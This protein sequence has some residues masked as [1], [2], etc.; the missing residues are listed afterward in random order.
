M[1]FIIYNRT[2]S[3]ESRL[4]LYAHINLKLIQ[5]KAEHFLA[6][7]N[8]RVRCQAHNKTLLEPAQKATL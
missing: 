5:Q 4:F 6:K 2:C 3:Q 1:L 8:S 7:K